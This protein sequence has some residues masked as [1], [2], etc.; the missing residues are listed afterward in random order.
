MRYM[1]LKSG[2]KNRQSGG[3]R[4]VIKNI[5]AEKNSSWEGKNT[6]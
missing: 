4:E 1:K 2:G 3:P 6:S 5:T